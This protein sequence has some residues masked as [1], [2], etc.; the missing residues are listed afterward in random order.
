MMVTKDL[1][2]RDFWTYDDQSAIPMD[3][4]IVSPSDPS[5]MIRGVEVKPGDK[6][7]ATCVYDSTDRADD[8]VFGQSTYDEMCIVTLI[9]RFK[10][11]RALLENSVGA[12]SNDVNDATVDL[13]NIYTDIQLHTFSC[14]VDNE[15]HTTDV[16]QGFLTETEDARDIWSDHPIEESDMCTFPVM[17]LGFE[18]HRL[19]WEVRNCQGGD[20]QFD[21]TAICDGLSSSDDANV[22]F[23]GDAI[24]G[25]TCVGGTYDMKSS[26][27][28]VNLTEEL[29]LENGGSMYVSY[30]C[31]DAENWFLNDAKVSQELT[32]E[33]VEYM[34]TEWYRPVCCLQQSE[35]EGE[36]ETIPSDINADESAL[37]SAAFTQGN[38]LAFLTA[39][40]AIMAMV[41]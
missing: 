27:E 24:A 4:D 13:L 35:G 22:E 17:N 36:S 28:D 8:T 39:T 1:K 18:D 2:S 30:T 10:T 7:Q 40:A 5:T 32:D 15:N 3:N 23:L 12:T 25:Y 41:L 21:G 20:T 26:H 6:I 11:P 31:S 34:R 16:Y 9:V 14:E 38:T 37:S 33:L 29:C 19:T